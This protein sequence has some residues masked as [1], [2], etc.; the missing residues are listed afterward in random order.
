MKKAIS[1]FLCAALVLLAAC[2]APPAT[3]PPASDAT[4]HVTATLFPQYDFARRIAGDHAQIK[5]LIPP[6]VESHSF[7]PT[8]TDLI[9]VSESDLFLSTGP[10]MEPWTVGILNGLEGVNMIDLS[11]G[12]P[13][14]TPSEAD[15]HEHTAGDAHTHAYDPHI[16]TSPVMA[17]KMV[18]RIRDALCEVDPK[19]ASDY[20][21]NA[22]ALLNNLDT[23]D[24]EIREIVSTSPKREVMFGSRFACFYFTREYGLD[25][26]SPYP[27]CAGEAEP[28]ARTLTGLIDE[29]RAEQVQVVFYQELSE[30][31]VAQTI[32]EATGAKMLLF[33]SCH[34]VSKDEFESGATYL[35]LMHQN[36]QNLKEGL[37]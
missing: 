32:A 22:Y 6:G 29:M 31:K 1:L 19:N 9:E 11:E 23:L 18:E 33:H 37:A 16:W 12:M 15:A 36:A 2:G 10:E 5:L 21:E 24:A 26:H 4:L 7:D 34:N 8:P 35:S 3:T 30:T 13:L 20:R 27:S 28:S 25:A 14:G 17:K